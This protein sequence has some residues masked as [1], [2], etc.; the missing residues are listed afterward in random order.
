MPGFAGRRAELASLDRLLDAP[1]TDDTPM[2]VAI[3]AIS[4]TAGVGKTALALRWAHQAADRFPDGQLYLNPRGYDPA[5]TVY[6][7]VDAL[8]HVLTAL[9]VPASRMP[10]ELEGQIGLYRSLL[11]GKRVLIVLDNVRDAQ[12]ARRLLPG[13]PGC[14][15][16][17]TG[18]MSE[19]NLG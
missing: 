11:A 16:I 6:D 3:T 4:G 17:A 9:G 19:I 1:Q 13:A 2:A 15:A 8:R 18:Q 12:H 14:L 7:S 5:G 10:A